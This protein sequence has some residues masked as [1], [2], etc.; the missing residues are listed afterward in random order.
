MCHIIGITQHK[1]KKKKTLKRLKKGY[2]NYGIPQK[3]TICS[4]LESQKEKIRGKGQ[5]TD[6]KKLMAT[7]FLNLGKDLDIQVHEANRSFQNLK[8]TQ[9]FPKQTITKLPNIKEREF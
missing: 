5:N 1:S 7:T 8:Q 6:F 9:Y 4:L 2:G 3:G